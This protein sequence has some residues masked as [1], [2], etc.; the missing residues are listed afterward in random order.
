MIDSIILVF[1]VI[2]LGLVAILLFR[3]GH[4]SD[5]SMQN[6]L[7]VL[8]KTLREENDNRSLRD[9]TERIAEQQAML[10]QLTAALKNTNDTLVQTLGVMSKQ[11]E[12]RLESLTRNQLDVN[13]TMLDRAEILR[14][15][16]QESI[17]NL[18]QDNAKQLDKMR[19]TV[20]EKLGETLDKRL[21]ASFQ[22]VSERL[23]AVYEGL[24]EMRQLAVGVGDLKKVLTNVKAR[25]TWGEVQLGMLLEQVLTPNQF[26]RNVATKEG[27]RELVEYAICLPGRDGEKTVYLPIDAK[28]PQEDYQR[29]LDAPD[30]LAAEEA[31]KALEKRIR[32]EASKI[33]DK[34]IDPPHTTD[35]ALM[36]L[37]TEGLYAEVL[38]RPGLADILQRDFKVVLSG[39]TT[40]LAI[41][42]S[43]QMGFNTLA[44]EKRSSEIWQL[45][46]AIKTEFGKFGGLLEKT[47]KKLQETTSTIELAARKSRTIERKLRNVDALPTLETQHLLSLDSAEM[48]EDEDLPPQADTDAESQT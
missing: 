46:G 31:G 29:L 19:A 45:L 48:T 39:P 16:T 35:F 33:R 24:G 20:D 18:Q 7:D 21:N 44:I 15:E 17:R 5:K 26:A 1:V 40:L 12:D 4:G 11:Q 28:F 14:R 23:V 25:G 41:L 8:A 27:S 37:P 3:K 43:L 10:G 13:K 2:L 6:A 47:Q 42:N 32:D 22:L 34:Y 36:F 38:R 30:N 9:R